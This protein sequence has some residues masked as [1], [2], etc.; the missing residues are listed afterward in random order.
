MY[1]LLRD[2][3]QVRNFK[4]K[5]FSIN[6]D[7][8]QLSRL[9]NLDED[10]LYSLLEYRR[11]LSDS[12]MSELA[13]ALNI[14]FEDIY[15]CRYVYDS[16]MDRIIESIRKQGY[17]AFSLSTWYNENIPD[18]F[19]ILTGVLW[20]KVPKSDGWGLKTPS[21]L[22][23]YMERYLFKKMTREKINS[24][25]DKGAVYSFPYSF[26]DRVDG[27]MRE[28]WI[29][30]YYLS[31][32]KLVVLEDIKSDLMLAMPELYITSIIQHILKSTNWIKEESTFYQVNSEIRFVVRTFSG[33]N[34][35]KPEYTELVM[36]EYG[37]S[38]FEKV[39]LKDIFVV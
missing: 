4:S 28:C 12:E 2:I 11:R 19:A 20:E 17:G 24:S 32:K 21:E 26:F 29:E 37:V 6:V 7:L 34:K 3:Q 13:S 23:T 38:S 39:D 1:P 18:A 14:E 35:L 36:S 9:I 10:S 22:A 30:M 33:G 5:S 25:V 8:Q 31:P 27:C 16:Y 15:E